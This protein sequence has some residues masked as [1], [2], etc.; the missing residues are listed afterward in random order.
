MAPIF[1][2]ETLNYCFVRATRR[3]K[4]YL[5]LIFNFRTNSRTRQQPAISRPARSDIDRAKKRKRKNKY[6]TQNERRI[7][8]AQGQS[9]NNTQ[10]NMS[11]LRSASL[12]T[13]ATIKLNHSNDC[14]SRAK[15]K[16][17]SS[18]KCRTRSAPH[19]SK[20]FQNEE[21]RK[22]LSAVLCS[23][24]AQQQQQ[25]HMSDS[26]DINNDTNTSSSSE[27]KNS[28]STVNSNN[29]KDYNNSNKRWRSITK[30]LAE[31][32][33]ESRVS[34]E[35]IPLLDRNLP[36]HEEIT[37]GTL[38]NGLKYVILPNK[39][40]ERRFEAHLEMHVGSVDERE[41]EQG[42][43]HLVE[44]VTFLGSRKRDQYLGSGTRGNAYTDFHHT[45]FHIHAPTVNKDGIYMFE[46]VL[47]ILYDVAFNPA[48][49]QTRIQKEKKAVL[50]EAQMMNTIEYRVDCQ[51]LQH[52]H[53]DNA[54]G[55]RFPIGK[56]D[57][58]PL[59]EDEKIRDFH[60]RWYFPSNATL[61]VV[62]EFD[63]DT[64]Q[65]EKMIEDAFNDAAPSPWAMQAESPLVRHEVRP[66]VKH[67]FG[68]PLEERKEL[69]S[70]LQRMMEKNAEDPYQPFI[71]NEGKP[72]LFQHEHLTHASFNIFS[73]L[74]IVRMEKLG[75]LHRT[76]LQRIALLVLQSRIQSRYSETNADYKRVELD[77]SDSARE[78]C[79]VSTVTVTCEPREWE[80][81]LQVAVEEARR[82]QKCGL[83]QGELSRFKA[84]MM[85]DSEQL[86]Q[87]AGCVPSLEN[88][89]FVMEHDALG[90]V[91]MDQVEGHKSLLLLDEYI[92][93]ES[94]NESATE[95]LGFIAEY[96]C[97]D[98]TRDPRSGLTTA[99]VACVPTTTTDAKT[100]QEVAFDITPEDIMR[101]LSADYGEIEPMED[102]HVPD[103]LISNEELALLI[104]ERK[105][106]L[107]SATFDEATG[108]YQR[109]LNNNV[110]VNYKQLDAEPGSA[111]LRLIV[112]G[113]RSHEPITAGPDGIGSAALGLRTLQEAGTIGEWDRKQ[114]ELLTMENLLVFDVEPEMEY[115]FLDAAFA[116][117][118]GLRTILEII[119]LLI[120]KPNWE[121]SALERVKDIYRM[122]ELN[123]TK[124]LEL[125]THDAI[126]KAMYGDRRFM[127]PS[128]A[129]LSALTLEGVAKAV[130]T[131]FS[132]GPIEINIVGDLIPEEVD[133]LITQVLGTISKTKENKK[134]PI[135]EK[136][137]PL[138]L[139]KVSRNDPVR[140]QRNW[141]RDSDDRACAVM[142]GPGPSMWAP[143]RIPNKNDVEEEG[144]LMSFNSLDPINEQAQANGN[145]Y[146][147]QSIRRKNGLATYIAGML[148]SEIVGGRLFT[149][150]R[151]ALG[152]TY[153]C[154]FNLSFGLQNSD[155]TTYRLLVT[156]TPAKIDEALA[157][158]IRV[159]R[160]F[161]NQRVSQREL[162][163][164]RNTLLA[165]HETDLKSNHYWADLM[166]CS[167]L[168]NLAENKTIEC[169]MDLP[170]MYEA[171]TVDDLHEVYDC[172]G[173][174]D[175]EMFTAITVAGSEEAEAEAS[176]RNEMMISTQSIKKS[177]SNTGNNNKDVMAA[178]AEK[179]GLEFSKNFADAFAKMGKKD[180]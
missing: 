157:A 1:L 15:D 141:L 11:S 94:V 109:R 2:D 133:E 10:I 151:D 17:T 6:Q 61:Y 79:T 154:N 50:A 113:G 65:V 111:F 75:D 22:D 102:V 82:L 85:R 176:S 44:H 9:Y 62:G 95:L 73:K 143:M 59:W 104:E 150:V 41:D 108:V 90:H 140:E 89:D 98:S 13:N 137:I 139:K 145:P 12:V 28:T 170:L 8:H 97:D 45:V 127:D 180:V 158:G 121:E 87:Q 51:L 138:S 42:L 20:Q 159:L 114:V 35:V 99:I 21:R 55:N 155:A 107:E 5:I 135:M 48:L 37:R 129:E 149:T 46:N 24:S 23:S 122:F 54:L 156:S 27:T 105:P 53:W 92:T 175:G 128:R 4:K 169:I 91:V 25:Q 30:A 124:N 26:H 49:L 74:P 56:L 125:M 161:R 118:G 119:H 116:V 68:I 34:E 32:L 96:G 163:R 110:R 58:V 7:T 76:I 100:D 168:E 81:A 162:D 69:E 179:L 101:V 148:L 166:Q 164:A 14:R 173:L 19:L 172:L 78:G 16:K 147:L 144:G 77:H 57:Q 112:P 52:L 36:R 167:S 130:E 31:T 131:Q 63:A 142:A 67:A 160:G 106:A 18:L 152:L 40:P 84:A 93:L 29:N 43:A 33:G 177:S 153:D 126:N 64:D 103:N 70:K 47:D 38:R 72:Q 171:C 165:R 120:E 71:A 174:S 134:V 66:P 146:A 132:N 115:L 117:D 60:A 88:L 86:A 80:F 3:N 123:T 83:T 39:T 178:A 136:P